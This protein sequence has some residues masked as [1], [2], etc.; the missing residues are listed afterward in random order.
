MKNRGRLRLLLLCCLT[1]GFLSGCGKTQGPEEAEDD[2]IVK[3]PYAGVVSMETTPVIDYTLPRLLPNI[4]VDTRG[5]SAGDGKVAAVK[6]RKL[7]G[8][9][10]LVDALTGEEVYRGAVEEVVY[11]DELGLY[12][13]C[14]DFSDFR[15]NGTYYLEC[16]IIGCSASFEIQE[17]RY[18][19]LFA[20]VYGV[21][22]DSI[23]ERELALPEAVA[24]LE[25]YEWYE[26]IFPDEDE[27]SIPDV[28]KELQ[29]WVS[30]MEGNGVDEED[31]AL[32]AAFLAKFSYL[33]QRFDRRYATDCLKRASTVFGQ[34]KAVIGRDA[35][36]FFA[37]TELYR[38]TGRYTYRRQ[39]ADYK[40]FFE[41]NSSY[42]EERSYLYAA[43]TYMD[44]RQRVDVELCRNFMGN[45]RDRAE[46]T[47]K[48]CGDMTH[49]VAA[50]NNG[51]AD[52]LK[53]VVEL[54]CA[55]Y[56]MNNYQYTEVMEDFLHYLMGRNRESVCYYENGEDRGSY[57]LLF[58]QMAALHEAAD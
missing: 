27:D 23:R 18:T 5:Y 43:M 7:P 13:G 45:L 2:T 31:E 12:S 55:N 17:K 8:E 57:L 20:E 54:S 6:G 41:D 37:L 10:G 40:S 30:Y 47:S 56:I 34:A 50:R 26:D 46:E 53:G 19:D 4:L 14:L 16:D 33:Y 51:S 38:A 42:L 58:A 24:L 29:G 21:M 22:T 36:T 44:T 39:I 15:Q 1:A 3:N 9:F 25:A 11:H 35:D 49:P 48:H 28:L 52:L 32:Y